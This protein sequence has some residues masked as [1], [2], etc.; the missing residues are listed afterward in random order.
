MQSFTSLL[1]FFG[2]LIALLQT[3]VLAAPIALGKNIEQLG[4]RILVP[5]GGSDYSPA[6]ASDSELVLQWLTEKGASYA[7]PEKLVFYTS[8]N[9]GTGYEMAERFVRANPSYKTFWDLYGE[10]FESDFGISAEDVPYEAAE[11]MSKAMAQYASQV[12]RVFGA[13]DGTYTCL[14]PLKPSK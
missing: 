14:F 3:S 10:D 7:D 8:P 1:S 6:S 9:G 5:A 12:T 11:A 4:K 2:L 13:S